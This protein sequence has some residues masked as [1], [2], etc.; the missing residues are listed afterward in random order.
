MS[1]GDVLREA[2]FP[3]KMEG[4]GITPS[5]F[6]A[7]ILVC[8]L[9]IIALLVR[10]TIIPKFKDVPNR[11]QLF[12]EGL[13]KFFDNI[14]VGTADKNVGLIGSYIFS[15]SIFI[16]FGTLLELFGIAPIMAS[17][18]ACIALAICTFG[19]L[20]FFSFKYKGLGGISFLKDITLPISMTFR[21]Y[22]SI[23]SGYLIM[24]L[25]YQYI[26]LAFVVPAFLSVVFTL[27]HAFI[28]AYI[29]AMLS[30][31]FIGEAM[32]NHHSEENNDI[33]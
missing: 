7:I 11:L 8:I 31:L 5:L 16:C 15:A 25:I 13:V 27:F 19:M 32:I 17:I 2:M 1:I 30:S 10:I 21:L 26:F 14:A 18:N 12:L 23:L 20:V 3:E 6:G 33:V 24:V 28:Q 9:L 29:F 22:G 4:I